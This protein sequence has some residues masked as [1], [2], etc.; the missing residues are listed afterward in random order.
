MLRFFFLAVTAVLLVSAA[1][2]L[3]PRHAS[4]PDT[5]LDTA[6]AATAPDPTTFTVHEAAPAPAP[7]PPPAIPSPQPA[8]TQPAQPVSPNLDA[9][10]QRL[11]AT[12]GQQPDSAAPPDAPLVPPAP[13]VAPVPPPV[14]TPSQ[15][16]GPRWTNV[17]AHGARWRMTP[18]A[19][20]FVIAIDIG[21]N[22]VASVH[23]APAFAN[24]DQPGM[25][26]RVDFLK[27]TILQN[28]PPETA[29]YTFARDG[30]VSLDH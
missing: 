19:D 24:L 6:P 4:R 7:A 22:R 2:I 18:A 16:T 8:A 21:G 25:N 26:Q 23:V 15:P 30:S 20:G 28:F 9:V 5:H 14:I 13:V 29:S 12:A 17:T 3:Q 11:R 1:Y 10:M 27:Q